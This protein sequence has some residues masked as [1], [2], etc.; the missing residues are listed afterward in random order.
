MISNTQKL[1]ESYSSP[2]IE[3]KF[4]KERMLEVINNIDNCFSRKCR[5]GHF[6]ASAFLLNKEKTHAL[7][8]HHAKLDQWMQLGGHCD[9]DPDVLRVS[10]KEAQEESGIQDI[11]PITPHIFD[12]DIHLIPTNPKDEAHYH[13]DIRFLLHAY[14]NDTF[15]K[16]HES[17]ELRWIAKDSD[18]IP[19]DSY[20]V[21][22]MFKK[23]RNM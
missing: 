4:Y 7:L 5:I 12:I 17:K 2:Y 13:F 21:K 20:S 19:G 15:Y 3:E 11:K 22:R 6:T 10:I 18:N 1:L 14:M 8:M 23:W 9:D 16:N